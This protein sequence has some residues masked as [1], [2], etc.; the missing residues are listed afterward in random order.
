[1]VWGVFTW[2]KQ[3]LWEEDVK[4]ARMSKERAGGWVRPKPDPLF[5]GLREKEKHHVVLELSGA[6]TYHFWASL[7]TLVIPCMQIWTDPHSKSA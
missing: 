1:M 3:E 6:S 7:E 2:C 4:V 5:A